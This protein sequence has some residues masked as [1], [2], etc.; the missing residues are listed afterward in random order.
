MEQMET[1]ICSDSHILAHGTA[2]QN[3]LENGQEHFGLELG[4]PVSVQ[5]P[6][7]SDA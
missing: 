3:N 2:S 6:Q 1:H 4:A 7:N 5:L